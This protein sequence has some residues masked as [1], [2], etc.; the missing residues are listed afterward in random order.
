MNKLLMGIIGMFL[1]GVVFGFF[2]GASYYA[3][4]EYKSYEEDKEFL[5]EQNDRCWESLRKYDPN[6]WDTNDCTR[7]P[8]LQGCS[9]SD[10]NTCCY[11]T[12]TLMA[13]RWEEKYANPKQE[14]MKDG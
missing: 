14:V 12:C 5:I 3:Q 7:N 13:C 6:C 2:I 8:N 10:C 1:V 11:G 9:K 4:I